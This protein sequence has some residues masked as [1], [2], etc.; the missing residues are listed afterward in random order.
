MK[1]TNQFPRILSLQNSNEPE[2]NRLIRN[3]TRLELVRFIE[4]AGA[5]LDLKKVRVAL[6]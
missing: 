4:W 2:F 3:M 5:G 1:Q 6:S